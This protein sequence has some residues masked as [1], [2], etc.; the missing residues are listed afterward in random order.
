MEELELFDEIL[1]ISDTFRKQ[2]SERQQ[3]QQRLMSL[4]FNLMV[5][6]F[7][8]ELLFLLELFSNFFVQQKQLNV[9]TLSQ[10]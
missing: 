9:I 5:Q 2:Y 8:L 7:K 4:C 6:T 10:T 1:A 3:Q